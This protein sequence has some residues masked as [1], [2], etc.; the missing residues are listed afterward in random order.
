[1]KTTWKQF[2]CSIL[3]LIGKCMKY[4]LF[5]F[6]RFITPDRFL[7]PSPK[8]IYRQKHKLSCKGDNYWPFNQKEETALLKI[9][10]STSEKT[11]APLSP[12]ALASSLQGRVTI[13]SGSERTGAKLTE[14]FHRTEREVRLT[15]GQEEERLTRWWNPWWSRWDGH[16]IL[17]SAWKP[18]TPSC[19]A[20]C[21]SSISSA[22][23]IYLNHLSMSAFIEDIFLYLF[24]WLFHWKELF[25]VK[26]IFLTIKARHEW[27]SN[28]YQYPPLYQKISL[29]NRHIF[30]ILI[31]LT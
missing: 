16:V 15:A 8:S 18:M 10:C 3:Q 24:P 1:M 28:I 6:E 23:Q 11:M 9:T 13:F 31:N 29:F 25:Q 4:K 14:T 19:S 2:S 30:K 17:P 12:N 26:L 22:E 5:Q 21:L 20:L 7:L 27:P